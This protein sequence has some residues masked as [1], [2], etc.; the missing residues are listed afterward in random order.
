MDPVLESTTAKSSTTNNPFNS[1]AAATT[2][3]YA[4]WTV[5]DDGN[6]C[7]GD[8]TAQ[9]RHLWAQFNYW[10]EGI[11]TLILGCV[12]L[13]GNMFSVAVLSTK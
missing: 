13:L 5:N 10:C 11:L 12:G 1:I 2:T 4:N 6:E 9:Y 8:I 3:N 7:G